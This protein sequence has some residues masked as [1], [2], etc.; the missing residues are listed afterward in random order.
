[1]AALTRLIG[2]CLLELVFAGLKFTALPYSEAVN[3]PLVVTYDHWLGTCLKLTLRTTD[4]HLSYLEHRIERCSR[5]HRS[6]LSSKSSH[7]E[8]V[9]RVEWECEI[10][11][12]GRGG[13]KI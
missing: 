4:P 9:P 2:Q 13:Q 12:V 7:V 8:L 5:P 10:V 11:W 1:M 3:I 6:S